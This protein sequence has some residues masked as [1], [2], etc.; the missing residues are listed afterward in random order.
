MST[1]L[2]PDDFVGEY[3]I[4]QGFADEGAKIQ[5]YIDTY[6][7]QYLIR[8]LGAE[9][10]DIFNT[11]YANAEADYVK[12]YEVLYFDSELLCRPFISEGME[13]MLKGFVYSHFRKQDLGVATTNGQVEMKPEGGKLAKDEY[14]NIIALYNKSV[15]TSCAIRQY[16]LENLTTYP[17]YKG[18][19][20]QFTWLV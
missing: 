19:E 20:L 3:A 12:L 9:L 11:G 4:A 5:E 14:S 18:V 1:Y 17:T 2:T 16:I 7:R 15:K 10:Y 6:E 13:I 8:L